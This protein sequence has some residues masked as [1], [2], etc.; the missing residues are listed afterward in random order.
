MARREVQLFSLSTLDV[1]TGALGA[2]IFLF[3]IVP[4]GGA[5][6]SRT[7]VQAA[8]SYDIR[9]KGLW[10][11]TAD[12]LQNKKIGDTLLIVIRDFNEMPKSAPCP[13]C[14][15]CASSPIAG[16]TKPQTGG[17]IGFTP[18]PDKSPPPQPDKSPPSSPPS[19]LPPDKSSPQ[20]DKPVYDPIKEKVVP[21]GLTAVEKGEYERLKQVE[22]LPNVPC[23]VAFDLFW[24]DQT[25]NVDIFVR[26]GDFVS[27]KPSKR[28]NPTIG[29]WESGVSRTK[30]FEKIDLRTN[31]EGVRQKDKIISGTYEIYGQFKATDPKNPKSTIQV[32]GLFYTN[33]LKGNERG[34]RYQSTLTL[35]PNGAPQKL[36]TVT[37]RADGTFDFIKN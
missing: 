21:I 10:G 36:A 3:I 2:V 22:I 33:D 17:G 9:S 4:K 16:K 25:D 15:D 19:S 8:L 34:K 28:N 31:M 37:L 18:E 5:S 32:E 7:A 27:G 11:L 20:P 14:P 1:L 26:K 12:S 23:M 29:K 13:A 6:A 35:S 24:K 30:L